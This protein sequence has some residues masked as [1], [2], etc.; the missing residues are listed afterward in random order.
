MLVGGG[1]D[2]AFEFDAWGR[3][4]SVCLCS[5]GGV[6]ELDADDLF[7]GSSSSGGDDAHLTFGAPPCRGV[8][9]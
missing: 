7:G 3:R 4:E 5:D 8:A 6:E 1:F 9:K 2:D